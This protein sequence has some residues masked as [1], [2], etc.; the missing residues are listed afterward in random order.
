MNNLGAALLQ[1]QKQSITAPS[2]DLVAI[3]Q[4]INAE[5]QG[6]LDAINN[7]KAE[8]ESLKSENETLKG[9]NSSLKAEN[10]SLKTVTNKNKTETPQINFVFI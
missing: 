7:L 6:F 10:E 5:R 8:N 2:V 1:K 4:K 9:E 3:Q